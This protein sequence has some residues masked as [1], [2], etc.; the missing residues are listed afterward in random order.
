MSSTWKWGSPRNRR[1]RSRWRRRAPRSMRAGSIIP[2]RSAFLHCGNGSRGITARR[3]AVM[4][5]PSADRGHDGLIRRVHPGVPCDV[6]ARRSR[7]G[8][9]ARLSAVS[10]HPHRA[11]LRAGADRDHE[12]H[13]SCADRRGA[14]GGAS[15]D[16]AQGRAGR[17]SRQSD[18][19]HDVARG[20]D[21]PD[22]CRRERRHP[23]HLG[24]DLSR[25][26]LRVSRGDGGRNFRP[27]RS[28]SIHSRNISA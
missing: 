20:A 27:M 12:R 24:R 3:M 10:P 15:Q 13:A 19:H 11:R 22:P 6:R 2:P 9:R 21:E 8:D 23:L 16:A 14:A 7:C 4:S 5:M 25:A 1:R 28:S 18:R 17:Q 26:R